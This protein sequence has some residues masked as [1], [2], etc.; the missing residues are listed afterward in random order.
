MAYEFKAPLWVKILFGLIAL[1]LIGYKIFYTQYLA[2]K[3]KSNFYQ[4]PFS[5]KV[6]ESNMFENRTIEFHLDNGL[7]IYFL[8]PVGDKILIDDSV[9]KRGNTYI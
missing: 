1:V 4:K 7:K 8:P 3:N 6:V 2:D 9:I 5:A